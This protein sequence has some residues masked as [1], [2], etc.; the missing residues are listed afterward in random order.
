MLTVTEQLF[1]CWLWCWCWLQQL[2]CFN[3][4]SDVDVSFLR[5]PGCFDVGVNTAVLMLTQ[6]LM[7]AATVQLFDVGVNTVAVMLTQT[8]MLTATTQLFWCWSE[9]SCFDVDSDVD[10]DCD[11]Q[12]FWCWLRCR[13]WLTM[14]AQLFCSDCNKYCQ[15]SSSVF[16]LS[17]ASIF[18]P[19]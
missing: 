18:F 12:L 10:V 6:T 8:L 7:L 19:F 16:F 13:C 11:S 3:V 5:Q 14:T 15:K 4:D 2:S 1:W 17:S 9:H